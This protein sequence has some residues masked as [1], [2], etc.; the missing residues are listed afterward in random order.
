MNLAEAK[1]R[2]AQEPVHPF[3][4]Q[5]ALLED[6]ELRDLTADIEANGLAHPLVRDAGGLLIDGRNR[7]VGCLVAGVEPRYEPLPDG[8]DPVAYIFTANVMRR[9]LAP[10]S[11]A[12]AAAMTL[13]LGHNSK[14]GYRRPSDGQRALAADVAGTSQ[15]YISMAKVVRQYAPE[16]VEM[17]LGGASLYDA[18]THHAKPRKDE[19]ELQR[20][21]AERI[22]FRHP[23][24]HERLQ[25]GEISVERAVLEAEAREQAEL[26]ARIEAEKR[27]K[28]QRLARDEFP[29]KPIPPV[30]EFDAQGARANTAEQLEARSANRKGRMAALDA[31]MAWAT[32]L[33]NTKEALLALTEAGVPPTAVDWMALPELYVTSWAADIITGV[34]ALLEAAQRFQK[35]GT[36]VREVH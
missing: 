28:V 25:S 12:M 18:Y 20:A 22:R 2:L 31:E 33:L 6:A 15:S 16:L 17:V 7:Y 34:N 36:A 19:A 8:T 9:H 29:P 30:R 11:R 3:A 14:V 1:A 32:A 23:D 26:T 13:E 5:F 10:G 27:T 21:T 24:I 4:A 35:Q